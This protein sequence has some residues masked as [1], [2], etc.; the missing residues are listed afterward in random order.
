MPDICFHFSSERAHQNGQ[1]A[2]D[3][4]TRI[5]MPIEPAIQVPNTAKPTCYLHNMAFTNSIAN[6]NAADESNRIVLRTGS[7][8]L[9]FNA[10]STK[11]P[12]I[13]IKYKRSVNG[14]MQDFAMVCPVTDIDDIGFV[15]AYVGAPNY[16]T[17]G[18]WTY[19]G[20]PHTLNG[21]TV[22]QVYD[23]INAVFKTALAGQ[24]TNFI[25]DSM[26][27]L[28]VTDD[29]G[30][31]IPT[32]AFAVNGTAKVFEPEIP[33]S[34]AGGLCSYKSVSRDGATATIDVDLVNA[35]AADDL[36]TTEFQ[37]MTSAE[38]NTYIQ[39]V[40][41]LENPSAGAYNL[42]QSIFDALDGGPLTPPASNTDPSFADRNSLGGA[43]TV[44]EPTDT[45]FGFY[46]DDVV[47]TTVTLDID[48]YEVPDFELAITKA[49]KADSAFWTKA[50][51]HLPVT[52]PVTKL[53][54]PDAKKGKY[55]Q[56][57][58]SAEDGT[59]ASDGNQY[60]KLIS[61]TSDI[62]AD[63]LIVQ[64]APNI[65]IVGG[66]LATRVFGFDTSQLGAPSE[67]P[68][69]LTAHHAARIDRTRA[70]LF[71]APTIA[72][73]SYSTEGK[74]GGSAIAMV[75]IDSEVGDT[76]S[77]ECEVPVQVPARIAGTSLNHMT[78][79]L[80]NEDGEK[81]SLMG[82]RW[83]AQLILSF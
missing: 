82:D 56:Q 68:K 34:T 75:P 79:F 64:M 8:A 13:G 78:V 43:A 47:S 17:R 53:V 55:N 14:T 40:V 31:R 65:E 50:N 29:S 83:S 57:V 46:E 19:D 36:K 81:L 32:T 45:D 5:T 38:I 72:S 20:Q 26:Q 71:H 11:K 67:G 2:G 66:A 16:N 7:S 15:P 27:N 18:V 41:Q 51:S 6:V 70:I 52:H 30:N 74:R 49:A 24:N 10:G 9:K 63:R 61:L 22:S 73:G 69:L 42:A 35:A 3:D 33:G 80:T 44:Y 59:P 28:V 77:W 54:N 76:Q 58:K 60:V 12:W 39:N 25:K 23:A 48:A 37:F 62:G 4:K 21:L 1:T